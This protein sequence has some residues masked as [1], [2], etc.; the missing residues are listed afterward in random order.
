MPFAKGH[1][2]QKNKPGRAVK[3]P[4]KM[5]QAYRHVF[6]NP[7]EADET[8]GQKL[9]R[10]LREDEPSKFLDQLNR[11]EAAHASKGSSPAGPTNANPDEEVDGQGSRRDEGEQKAGELI[12]RILEEL[13]VA[14]RTAVSIPGVESDAGS[15]AGAGR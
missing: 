2:S 1:K 8:E 12:D 6:D 7:R 15:R 10:K 14:K 13:D 3:Q 9:I 5:L 11:L 4:S